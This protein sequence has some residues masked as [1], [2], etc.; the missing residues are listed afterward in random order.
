MPI[1]ENKPDRRG[2]PICP[3]CA[4][5]I[6]LNDGVALMEDSMIHAYCVSRAIVLG[7]PSP[8][9]GLASQ[10]LEVPSEAVDARKVS[11]DLASASGRRPCSRSSPSTE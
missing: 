5:P 1:L 2:R 8:P 10:L 11:L 9:F 7:S 6:L 4:Q 3:K